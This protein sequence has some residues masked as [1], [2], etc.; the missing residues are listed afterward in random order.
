M[1]RCFSLI[2]RFRKQSKAILETSFGFTREMAVLN[3]CLF[4]SWAWGRAWGF[5]VEI[6]FPM[7]GPAGSLHNGVHCINDPTQCG[8][9]SFPG[10]PQIWATGAT[11]AS[12]S[13]PPASNV[14]FWQ[15]RFW[16]QTW[17]WVFAS[18]VSQLL[19]FD[20]FAKLGNTGSRFP[21][22]LLRHLQATKQG[23]NNNT[24]NSRQITRQHDTDHGD[25]AT[26]TH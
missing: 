14:W 19:V 18:A 21:R 11:G 6:C 22:M 3:H 7:A 24:T 10:Q 13:W 12:R 15:V 4:L 8:P 5:V 2:N 1:Q 26:I 20:R 9:S 25:H 17:L 23:R 16:G